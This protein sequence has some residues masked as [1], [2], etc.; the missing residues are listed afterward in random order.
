MIAVPA[1]LGTEVPADEWL[2]TVDPE[3]AAVGC[4]GCRDERLE[5]PCRCFNCRGALSAVST[6]AFG[7]C[8]HDG[9]LSWWRCEFCSRYFDLGDMEILSGDGQACEP[10]V[11]N[12]LDQLQRQK[13]EAGRV[14]VDDGNTRPAPGA[15][16]LS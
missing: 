3:C 13:P 9:E 5:Y 10:C 8:Y 7:D 15:A 4:G 14:D 6:A 11:G 12:W 2:P 16:S 1:D